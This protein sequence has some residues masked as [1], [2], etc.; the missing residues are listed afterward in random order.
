[1]LFNIYVE[2]M[3]F[4]DLKLAVNCTYIFPFLWELNV[5]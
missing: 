2:A 1:M 4:E 3:G 5:D